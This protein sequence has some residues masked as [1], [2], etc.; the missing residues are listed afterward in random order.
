MSHVFLTFVL[1]SFVLQAQTS[2][3]RADSYMA[4]Q[5]QLVKQGITDSADL[6]F[7]SSASL[8]NAAKI[9]A[10]STFLAPC[11][12][13]PGMRMASGEQAS[14]SS[15]PTPSSQGPTH[16]SVIMT[17]EEFRKHLERLG[18]TGDI[19][20]N[21]VTPPVKESRSIL[22]LELSKPVTEAEVPSIKTHLTYLAKNT[23]NQEAHKALIS[24]INSHSKKLSEHHKLKNIDLFEI[25]FMAC[26]FPDISLLDAFLSSMQP[27]DITRYIIEALLQNNKKAA[28]YMLKSKIPFN[29]NYQISHNTSLFKLATRLKEP[30]EVEVPILQHPAFQAPDPSSGIESSAPGINNAVDGIWLI[31][32][33]ES[34]E[35]LLRDSNSPFVIKRLA[36]SITALFFFQKESSL[37]DLL[38]QVLSK[39]CLSREEKLSILELDSIELLDS[40]IKIFKNMLPL[41]REELNLTEKEIDIE[42]NRIKKTVSD[43]FAEERKREE[44]EANKIAR[45]QEE[46]RQA[47]Q[48]QA[49]LAQLA[50][51]K[52][53]KNKQEEK[54]LKSEQLNKNLEAEFEDKFKSWQE[55]SNRVFNRYYPYSEKLFKFLQRPIKQ[56]KEAL[57]EN[58]KLLKQYFSIWKSPAINKVLKKTNFKITSESASQIF[59]NTYLNKWRFYI[60]NKHQQKNM[61][62]LM[63][64]VGRSHLSKQ[65]MRAIKNQKESEEKAAYQVRMQERLNTAR[66]NA[67][68]Y[69][70]ENLKGCPDLYAAVFVKDKELIPYLLSQPNADF[71]ERF[72]GYTPLSF[73]IYNYP[74]LVPNLFSN[75]RSQTMLTTPCAYESERSYSAI[76]YAVKHL[77][78]PAL[79]FLIA[80]SNRL[81]I[82]PEDNLLEKIKEFTGDNPKK[83]GAFRCLTA[84]KIAE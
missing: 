79:K 34:L 33:P 6:L 73:A 31:Q 69:E 9:M 29:P 66:N 15:N 23:I 42:D 26:S 74:E 58:K 83:A 16:Q 54:R 45:Q 41:F 68:A 75:N 55:N 1:F 50:L 76:L 64:R 27:S 7:Q 37:L 43:F 46:E 12:Q 61:I 77:K 65:T 36:Y 84:Y 10:P 71:Y 49:N 14:A 47:L 40:H 4:F 17:P 51:E 62:H 13:V 22:Y 5:R 48:L 44:Y 30:F 38:K 28:C 35:T 80:E 39:S 18:M 78:A 11:Q 60:E 67:H 53:N 59:A 81:G 25:L 3:S 21:I 70:A 57:T 2:L 72:R 32:H 63:Q 8:G 82:K 20:E 56:E 24:I 19:K 52:E